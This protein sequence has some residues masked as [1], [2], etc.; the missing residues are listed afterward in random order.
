MTREEVAKEISELGIKLRHHS[1]STKLSIA[2]W[3]HKN[4]GSKSFSRN[5]IVTWYP[6]IFFPDSYI[7][8]ADHYQVLAHELV[9]ARR[10][11]EYGPLKWILKYL[12][13]SSFRYQ[14]ERLAYLREIEAGWRSVETVIRAL[15]G[16]LYKID[17]PADEMRAWFSK[18]L[19]R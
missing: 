1:D 9:H 15:R 8:L 16:P 17:V 3:Y 4:F 6:D 19:S 12:S 7:D 5:V 13:C 10:Q 14:E 11:K 2:V 18:R